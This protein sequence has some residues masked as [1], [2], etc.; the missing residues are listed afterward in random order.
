MAAWN[1]AVDGRQLNEIRP[2]LPDGPARAADAAA[3][4][5]AGAAAA[6]GGAVQDAPTREHRSRYTYRSIHIDV[7]A[8]TYTYSC[9]H[10]CSPTMHS[11]SASSGCMAYMDRAHQLS[12]G[13]CL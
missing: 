10:M 5:A 8:Y 3:A 4:V 1:A 2:G 6:G 11:L 12:R 13:L 9:V 7:Y